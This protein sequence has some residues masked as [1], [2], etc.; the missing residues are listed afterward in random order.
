M[1]T[2]D[3]PEV[4]AET[5]PPTTAS[6]DYQ[7]GRWCGECRWAVVEEPPCC[8]TMQDVVPA[9]L[10]AEHEQQIRAKVSD[11]ECRA[12]GHWRRHHDNEGCVLMLPTVESGF[13]EDQQCEC[14]GFAILARGAQ[15]GTR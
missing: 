15:G 14:P 13:T 7:S 6:A 11:E 2:A 3:V 4:R 5:M 1:T 12:C 8:F 10:L 9:A